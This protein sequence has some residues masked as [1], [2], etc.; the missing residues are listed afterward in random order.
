MGVWGKSLSLDARRRHI[1]PVCE[2]CDVLVTQ[3]S[4][5]PIPGPSNI[6]YIRYWLVFTQINM[7]IGDA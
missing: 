6:S 3:I 7:H 4:E 5:P 1:Y 2:E